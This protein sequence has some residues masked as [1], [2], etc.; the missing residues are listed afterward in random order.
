LG[1]RDLNLRK[2]RTLSARIEEIC[3]ELDITPMELMYAVVS[4]ISTRFHLFARR[5]EEE[6]S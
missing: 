2:I 4:L 1:S 3:D 6:P 5:F